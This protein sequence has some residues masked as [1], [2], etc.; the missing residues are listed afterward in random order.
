MRV[1]LDECVPQRLRHDIVGH[2]VNTV[3]AMGWAS[4]TNGDLLRL[5]EA[6]FDVFVTTDQRLSHQQH[7]ADMAIAIVVL[8]ARRNKLQLLQPLVPELLRVR[9]LLE[10]GQV[11]RIGA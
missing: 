2:L 5:A 4:K 3:P 6:N 1:L 11:K 9:P 8:I 10:P 7:V